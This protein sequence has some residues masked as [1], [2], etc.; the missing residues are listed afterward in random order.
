MELQLKNKKYNTKIDSA[1]SLVSKYLV[2]I[3]EHKK[4]IR[5]LRTLSDQ[6]KK[7]LESTTSDVGPEKS[8]TPGNPDIVDTP[9]PPPSKYDDLTDEER[10]AKIMEQEEELK[11]YREAGLEEELRK[12]TEAIQAYKK[13]SFDWMYLSLNLEQKNNSTEN[14]TPTEDSPERNHGKQKVLNSPGR[15]SPSSPGRSSPGLVAS[16][17]NQQRQPKNTKTE[18]PRTS[19][20][21]QALLYQSLRENNV[22]PQ[23]WQQHIEAHLAKPWPRGSQG[24]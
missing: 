16:P 17:P 7:E 15:Q 2:D 8:T 19:Q 1:N 10:V 21:V 5:K 14:T 18:T 12:A 6:R 23:L 3:K 4:E 20:E 9:T 13:L 11:N 24:T 22:L